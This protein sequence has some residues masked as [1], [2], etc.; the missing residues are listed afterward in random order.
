MFW[1]WF[2]WNKQGRPWKRRC[3][4]GSIWCSNICTS[5]SPLKNDVLYRSALVV[6]S[7]MCIYPCHGHWHPPYHHW[8]WLLNLLLITIWM[9][10]YLFSLEDTTSK[11]SKKQFEIWTGHAT[12]HFF[13]LCQSIP[14]ELG[15]REA[16]CVSGCCW[17]KAIAL[18]DRVLAC[19][20]RCCG[21][22]C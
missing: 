7:Q 8:C 17:Y 18:H 15:P 12:A 1:V 14:D 13:T 20:W 9:V 19:I 21:E 6:P 5:V 11:I 10:P 3:L 22:L 2:C 4:D 16:C